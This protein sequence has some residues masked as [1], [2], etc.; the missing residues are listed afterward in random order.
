MPTAPRGAILEAVTNN[1]NALGVLELPEQDTS[2]AVP[3]QG[4]NAALLALAAAIRDNVFLDPADLDELIDLQPDQTH[5]KAMLVALGLHGI[6]PPDQCEIAMLE[7]G[8]GGE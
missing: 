5:A 8:L 7:R 6:I 2:L 3:S 1:P 4:A